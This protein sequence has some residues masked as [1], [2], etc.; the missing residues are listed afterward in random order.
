M[1]IYLDRDK[2]SDQLYVSFAREPLRKGIV[3]K[4]VRLTEDIALD[5]GADGRLIGI[6]VMNASRNIGKHVFE[7][8]EIDEL[9]GVAEAARICGVRKSNFVR[10]L[11]GQ[12]DFPRPVA[13]LAS[14][15]I[16]LRSEVEAYQNGRRETRRPRRIA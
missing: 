16:W 11:A 2:D 15:R 12:P 5:L 4:S 10:D 8:L 9:V 6:D 13:E 1:R 3:K 7:P 14:G